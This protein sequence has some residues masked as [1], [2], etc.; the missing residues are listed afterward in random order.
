LTASDI[1]NDGYPELLGAAYGRQW[2]TIWTRAAAAPFYDDIA[3][4]CGVDGDAIRHGR[5]SEEVKAAQHKRGIE[6]EDELP[7]RTGG[8]TFSL[9]TADFDN[10]GDL[11]IFSAE[12]TH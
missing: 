4:N 8:N 10:D 3:A 5:Y 6:R 2:N 9:V 7:Y 1:N 12:I 11:D